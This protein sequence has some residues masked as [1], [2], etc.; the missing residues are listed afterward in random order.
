LT[1]EIW[2]SSQL[3]GRSARGKKVAIIGGGASAVEVLE[4]VARGEAE[5][6]NVLARSEKWI[7]PRNPFIDSLL[8]LNILGC[9]TIFSWIPESILRL[10]FYRD[11]YDM[12]PPSKN[13]KGIFEETLMVNDEVFDLMRSSKASW[14]RGDILGYDG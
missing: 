10:F 6:T 13:S 11:L 14:L 8:A 3:D 12:S 9:E 4:F 7:I 5:H 2:Y 1:G